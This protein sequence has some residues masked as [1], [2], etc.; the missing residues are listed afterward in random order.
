MSLH[1]GGSTDEII[2]FQQ[3]LGAEYILVV[4]ISRDGKEIFFKACHDDYK[5][6]IHLLLDEAHYSFI[7]SPTA[8]FA[9]AYFCDYCC[10][11][12]TTKFGHTRCRAKCNKCFQSPP[13]PLDA[14]IKCNTCKREFAN[15]TCLQNHILHGICEKFKICQECY[16]TYVV[17]KKTDHVCGMKYC[18]LCKEDMPVRHECYIAVTKRKPKPK[19]G[20][21][22]IFYDFECYQTKYLI[23]NDSS[24]KEH[25]IN[26]CVAHQA[27]DKCRDSDNLETIC[28]LCGQRENIFWGPN[29]VHDFMEY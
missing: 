29:I 25:E 17:K 15:A 6:S 2:K 7:L 8:A 28:E 19:F 9:T 21:L 27:C 26:L 3:Y 5:F 11:G 10:I 4:Y 16:T 22:Y 18:S 13:C 24:K 1:N 20:V 23:E 12:Y 14:I